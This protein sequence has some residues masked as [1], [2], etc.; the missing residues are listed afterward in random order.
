MAD[1]EAPKIQKGAFIGVFHIYFISAR[2]VVSENVRIVNWLQSPNFELFY[3]IGDD[4]SIY[5]FHNIAKMT[6][7]G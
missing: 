3:L 2:T 5:N 1:E 6:R 7:V 4:G